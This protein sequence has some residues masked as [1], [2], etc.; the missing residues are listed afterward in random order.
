MI[1]EQKLIFREKKIREG[2]LVLT[3]DAGDWYSGSLY[4]QL[5]A[6]D[7]TNSVPQMEFFHDAGYDGIILGNH[8]FDR[9]ES[10]LFAMLY[11]ANNMM[12]NIN[13]FVSNLIL[14]L[15]KESKFN[16][17]Y[18]PSSSVKFI[19]Y[20]IKESAHGRVGVLGYMTPDALFVSND[21]REDL[22]F[23]GY[24][25]PG[26]NKYEDLIEM[27]S[28]QSSMLKDKLKCDL[29]VVVIHGGH[30]DDEDVGFLNLPDV[31]IV[32][33][34]H[35]HVSYFY[36][37]SDTSLTS[38]CGFAG[39][40]LTSLSIGMDSERNLHFRGGNEDF[41]VSSRI[42]QCIH[43][44]SKMK[45]NDAFDK[46]VALWNGEM[47]EL[48][49][50]NLDKTIF[51]G[52]LTQIFQ[53]KSTQE[54]NALNFAH[55]LVDEINKW[56]QKNRPSI[57]DPITLTFWNKD[58]LGHDQIENRDLSDVTLTFDDAY[59]LIFLPATKDLYTFYVR[60]ED[61]YYILQGMFVL[62]KVV[63]PLLTVSA[64]GILY[65]ETIYFG[66]IPL[67]TNLRTVNNLP[68][69]SWPPFVRMLTN[70]VT[71]PYFWK[72]EKFS[73][74]ILNNIPRD[75]TG[76]VVIQEQAHMPYYPNELELFFNYLGSL[77]VMNEN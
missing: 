3:L 34:G 60:K 33:G 74:G 49:N 14:P 65:D 13:V 68:Y 18:E 2:D 66:K 11:K 45:Q 36:A 43:V 59:S 72:F 7:R 22:Q 73:H 46:K 31:D 50:Y 29:V 69:K 9:H 70:S 52:N 21:Y 37:G 15:P 10:A 71:A 64:G 27:A 41:D 42:P 32:L 61:I 35:T 4:D 62:N 57:S 76:N 48:F 25:F 75:K 44:T 77:S 8:D 58:F 39:I 40:Q 20:L 47:N 38:Q 6:D 12:L 17:F 51:R 23:V 55:M 16:L 67:I 28:K 1:F 63:S 5:G 30:L 56:E 26:G 24:S 53:E 54:V 19:P